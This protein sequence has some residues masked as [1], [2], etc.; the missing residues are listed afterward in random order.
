MTRRRSWIWM[1][2]VL[3]AS[4]TSEARPP[5]PSPPADCSTPNVAAGARPSPAEASLRS[6]RLAFAAAAEPG[7]QADLFV[8]LGDGSSPV[9]I[10]AGPR[11]EFSPTW[12]PDGSRIAYRVNRPGEFAPDIWA[13]RADGSGRRNLT[14][15]PDD[16]EWSP[17]WSPDGSRIAY[18]GSAS[19]DLGGDL[20]TMRPDGT[21]STRLTTDGGA[22]ASSEYPTWS[23]AG[24]R[25]AY[26]HYT[27]E[28][29]FEIWSIRAD[30]SCVTNLTRNPRADEWPAWS[31][32]GTAIAFMSDR[33]GVFGA[34][35][36]FVM[37]PDGSSPTNLTRTRRINESFPAWTP[38]GR[39]GFVRYRGRATSEP[40]ENSAGEIWI[41]GRDGSDPVRLGVFGYE[42]G[43]MAWT[44]ASP[45][46]DARPTASA[47]GVDR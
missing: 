46:A 25:L 30:G 39:I 27:Q 31:P 4:C 35:D 15:T 8:A 43:P 24:D 9:A 22:G 44:T 45:G 5:E 40:N 19:D 6:G 38:D 12:S 23:P 47:S 36:I 41:V 1:A 29:N 28:G 10:A 3:A 37:T 2:L 20:F 26:I 32:D 33:D 11:D 14:A 7:G 18:Y 13:M 16:T 42:L 21:G 34:G 17:A